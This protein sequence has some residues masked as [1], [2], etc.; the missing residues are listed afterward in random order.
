MNK[1][2]GLWGRSMGA[3]TALMYAA[4]D[5]SIGALVL[6]SPFSSLPDLALELVCNAKVRF[7]FLLFFLLKIYLNLIKKASYSIT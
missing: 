6:D 2:T 1:I 3:A 4:S 5:P 7:L